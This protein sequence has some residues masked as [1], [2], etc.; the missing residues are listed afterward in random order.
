MTEFEKID[1]YTLLQLKHG[2]AKYP[3]GTWHVYQNQDLGHPNQGHLEFLRVGPENTLKTAPK[4]LPDTPG[5]INWRYQHVGIIDSET[6]IITP[7][8]S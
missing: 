2:A 4:T 7:G 1:E 3:S 8:E 5:Q 6:G